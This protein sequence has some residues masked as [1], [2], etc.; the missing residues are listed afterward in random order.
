MGLEITI[1]K[2]VLRSSEEEEH[3]N[4]IGAFHSIDPDA[5]HGFESGADFPTQTSSNSNEAEYRS[6]K[7]IRW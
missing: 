3:K 2:S 6:R 7:L 5:S 4:K 1:A